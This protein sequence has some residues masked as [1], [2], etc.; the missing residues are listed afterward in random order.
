MKNSIV[1]ALLLA[2]SAFAFGIARNAKPGFDPPAASAANLGSPKTATGVRPAP[3]TA[4]PDA[5]AI[6]PRTHCTVIAALPFTISTPGRYCY[7]SNLA[8]AGGVGVEVQADNV[9]LDCANHRTTI[10]PQGAGLLAGIIIGG[11]QSVKIRNC[12]IAG[13]DYGILATGDSTGLRILHNRIEA[14][15][16][17]GVEASGRNVQV[18]GNRISN[19]SPPSSGGGLSGISTGS[20]TPGV[21]VAG[22]QVI[23]NTV[24]NLSGASNIVGIRVA[25]AEAPMIAGNTVMELGPASQGR[26]VAVALRGPASGSGSAAADLVE[27]QLMSRVASSYVDFAIDSPAALGLCRGNISI[28]M[29]SSLISECASGSG[30]VVVP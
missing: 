8:T 4:Q 3:E 20:P 19:M 15:R 9:D 21:R 1:V 5:T 6:K 30:N 13:S 25:Q 11:R 27:N 26:A 2:G 10:A 22:V 29:N 16:V 18:I 23:D 12:H 28:G 17:A 14:A 24:V 7:A